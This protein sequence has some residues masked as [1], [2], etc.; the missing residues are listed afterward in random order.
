M[1]FGIY[2]GLAVGLLLFLIVFVVIKSRKNMEL[3]KSAKILSNTKM[4]LKM[5]S[6]YDIIAKYFPLVL[7]LIIW[8]SSLYRNHNEGD[9]IAFIFTSISIGLILIFLHICNKHARKNR[10]NKNVSLSVGNKPFIEVIKFDDFV[11]VQITD[12]GIMF[13]NMVNWRWN[14]FKGYSKDSN[15]LILIPKYPWFEPYVYLLNSGRLENIIK[16]YLREIV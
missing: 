16:T 3:S 2:L 8:G 9:I 11:D 6:K 4:K 13:K 14:R 12:K 7:Y 5:G 15:C 10:K 1:D